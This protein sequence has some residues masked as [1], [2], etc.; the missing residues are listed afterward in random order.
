MPAETRLELAEVK[1]EPRAGGK[2]AP[3]LMAAEAQRLR[4][5]CPKGAWLVALDERGLRRTTAQL[6]ER[7]SAWRLAGRDVAFVIGGPDGLDEAFKA[8]A[9]ETLRL[10]D[11]TLPHA[12]VRVLLAEQL[13]R[14]WSILAKHPYHR[15]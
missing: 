10:S 15:D 13:Y 14:S 8:Q 6:G 4:V 11:L 1:A 7:L 5:A 12:L 2:T 9:D 3:Q